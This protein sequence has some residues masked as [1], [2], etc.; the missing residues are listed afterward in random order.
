M[1]QQRQLSNS[2]RQ[3]QLLETLQNKKQLEEQKDKRHAIP[4]EIEF[5]LLQQ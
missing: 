1:K 5:D 3:Q 2:E 4:A